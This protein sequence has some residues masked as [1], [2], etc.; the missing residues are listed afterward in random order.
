MYKLFA[1]QANELVGMGPGDLFV[2]RNVGN[3]CTHK[4]MNAMSC[5]EVR[6]TKLRF[7]QRSNL[8][9]FNQE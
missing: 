8:S 5:M 7:F 9:V 2:H 6:S 4:D 3:L 1:M